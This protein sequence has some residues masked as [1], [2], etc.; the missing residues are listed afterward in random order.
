MTDMVNNLVFDEFLEISNNFLYNENV[1]EATDKLISDLC[2]LFNIEKL[3]FGVKMESEPKGT[4]ILLFKKSEG[5][6]F[7]CESHDFN[8]FIRSFVG[9]NKRMNHAYLNLF[10]SKSYK[11]TSG[12]LDGIQILESLSYEVPY[13]SEANEYFLNYIENEG[14]LSY[15]IVERSSSDIKFSNAEFK[16]LSNAFRMMKLKTTKVQLENQLSNESKVNNYILN[17]ENMPICM[18]SKDDQRILEYN[19]YYEEVL[20]N[21][22]DCTYYYELIGRDKDFRIDNYLFIYIANRHWIKKIFLL[23]LDSG[24]EVYV[25]YAKDTEE[26]IKQLENIDLL[27][28]CLSMKGLEAYYD[29]TVCTDSNKYALLT[30]DIA[31]FK[32]INSK[33]NLAKGNEVLCEMSTLLYSTLKDDEMFCR[34]NDDNFAILLKIDDKTPDETIT[35]RYDEIEKKFDELRKNDNVIKDVKLYFG[36]CLVD[37]YLDFT[38]LIDRAS[39]A[40][41]HA[42]DLS[43]KNIAMYDGEVEEM[44]LKELFIDE[45]TPC[46]VENDEFALYIQPKFDIVENKVVGS[47]AFVRWVGY[48]EI[49]FFPDEFIPHFEKNG[50]ITELDFIMF[51]KV[52]K[53]LSENIADGNKI[54]PISVNMSKKHINNK[55]EFTDKFLK[56]LDTYN[57]PKNLIELELSGE[58]FVQNEDI[59]T[60][61]VKLLKSHDIKISIDNFGISSSSIGLL[62]SIDANSIKIDRAFTSKLSN[63]DSKK[64][65]LL[66]K[67]IVNISNDLNFDLVCV[68]IENDTQIQELKSLGCKFGQGHSFSKPVSEKDFIEQYLK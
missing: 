57:I 2:G 7:L 34:L 50:F 56:L 58:A 33:Y 15:I 54:I 38:T 67:N 44:I 53:Y 10:E 39:M 68:G 59:F 8:F 52:M 61:F 41:K 18:V 31:K 19:A 4:P 1:K 32:T 17:N 65:I 48:D 21:I 20:P 37:K 26:H 11:T 30:L 42:K 49:I 36:A 13:G 35:I 9:E 29:K 22:V 60:E 47:E 12:E 51:E 55:E 6:S 23:T 28:T 45:R 3:M 64:E 27:T 43:N 40:R 24:E 14:T 62:S 46:A 63:L 5:V 25:I 66:L 16:M